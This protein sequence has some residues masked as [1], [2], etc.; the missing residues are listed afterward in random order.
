MLSDIPA[1]RHY[2]TMGEDTVSV[3]H[4]LCLTCESIMRGESTVE[5]TNELTGVAFRHASI[6]QAYICMD[7]SATFGTVIVD[8]TF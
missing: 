8:H 4:Y 3:M 2:Q 6:V 1:Y 7:R 5:L